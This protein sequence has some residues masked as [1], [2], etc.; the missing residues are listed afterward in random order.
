M[1]KTYK[2]YN[3]TEL[4]D[5]SASSIKV[6]AALHYKISETAELS[7]NSK[8]GTGDAILQATNRNRLKDFVLLKH[9]LEYR[10]NHLTMRAYTTIEDSGDTQDLSALGTFVGAGKWFNDYLLTYLGGVGLQKGWIEATDTPDVQQQKLI[11]QIIGHQ[12]ANPS[13]SFADLIGGGADQITAGAAAA[14][15]AAADGG[16]LVPGSPEFEAAK[17]AVIA[18][19]ISQGGAAIQDN[20]KSYSFEGNYSFKDKIEWADVIVGGS[21]KIFSLD[22]NGTLFTDYNAPIE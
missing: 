4:T 17:N 8:Y 2:G 18:N 11:Q 7:W 21:Y 12:G 3:E 19:P 20:S 22:S 10:N 1:K 14:A 6:D 15:Q 13:Q 5:Y 16:M 9:K